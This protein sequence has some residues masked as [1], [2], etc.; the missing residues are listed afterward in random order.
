MKYF[1]SYAYD[2][3]IGQTQTKITEALNDLCMLQN[4]VNA[5]QAQDPAGYYAVELEEKIMNVG[6]LGQGVRCN[7]LKRLMVLPSM[8]IKFW[9]ENPLKIVSADATHLKGPFGGVANTFAGMDGCNKRLTM[10]LCITDVENGDNW[11]AAS[12]V[13]IEKVFEQDTE[14][15]MS[16]RDKGLMAAGELFQC[17]HAHCAIHIARNL[18]MGRTGNGDITAL[19]KAPTKALYTWVLNNIKEKYEQ[20]KPNVDKKLDELAPL[21]CTS[22][23]LDSF[24]M[25]ENSKFVTNYGITSNNISES[26]NSG[27]NKIRHLPYSQLLIAFLLRMIQQFK[28]RRHD[29][30]KMLEDNCKIVTP[31]YKEV[32]LLANKMVKKKYNARLIS[33]IEG[34]SP[35]CTWLVSKHSVGQTTP[36]KVHTV[37]FAPKEALWTSRI[38]CPCRYFLSTGK[39]CQHAAFVLLQCT[40]TKG[41]RNTTIESIKD[42]FLKGTL[43]N[44]A[45]ECWYAPAFHTQ[46]CFDMYGFEPK[47]L[48]VLEDMA[49][50]STNNMLLPFPKLGKKP[51]ATRQAK[52][53]SEI[54]QNEN[55][56]EDEDDDDEDDYENPD[57]LLSMDDWHNK[58]CTLYVAEHSPERHSHCQHCGLP[59]HKADKCAAPDLAFMMS[60]NTLFTKYVKKAIDSL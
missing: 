25:K 36:I 8:A 5:L 23:L 46:R 17:V 42:A 45:D 3:T 13:A 49:M 24:S 1:C 59:G 9:K 29:Y 37:Q 60:K 21:F 6:D 56:D 41:H 12:K 22:H 47:P 15:L 31:V 43:T 32:E 34:D 27:L 57:S 50:L 33:C 53:A 10:M 7:Y 54:L 35:T 44:M 40:A 2:R 19:A 48:P 58:I 16:D 26:E 55:N 52:Q 18:A 11:E 38:I 51:G 14:L 20:S 28:E 39:P 4:V 30:A